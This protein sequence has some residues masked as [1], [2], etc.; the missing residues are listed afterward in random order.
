MKQ[1]LDFIETLS[2]DDTAYWKIPTV[3]GESTAEIR[4][5]RKLNPR[6][7][8]L[9][10]GD[11]E[12]WQDFNA[13]EFSESL[14]THKVDLMAFQRQLG[15]SVLSQAVFANLIVERAQDIFGE[16]VVSQ[17]M[18]EAK[19]FCAAITEAANA[20]AKQTKQNN[21]EEA[22]QAQGA[23]LKLVQPSQPN[24]T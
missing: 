12:E 4:W 13:K 14:N 1:L 21:E 2:I 17:S 19:R 16:K 18:E 10:F 9:R 5:K 23:K 8:Q 15:A 6:G 3:Y 20:L 11:Q 24:A 7:W 22:Q